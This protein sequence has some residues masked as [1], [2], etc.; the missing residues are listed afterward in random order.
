MLIYTGMIIFL[1]KEHTRHKHPH[2]KD[3]QPLLWQPLHMSSYNR[4]R[5][6]IST[7]PP[8]QISRGSE[9]C[10]ANYSNFRALAV[11]AA[12]ISNGLFHLIAIHSHGRAIIT[13]E[14]SKFMPF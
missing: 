8:T 5:M 1:R 3:G 2:V 14:G 10:R 7:V 11:I 9:Q 13:S 4:L 6:R 12:A